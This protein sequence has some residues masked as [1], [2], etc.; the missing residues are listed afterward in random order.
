MT[1]STATK[2][3]DA[4]VAAIADMS[5]PQKN[6]NNPAFDSSYANLEAVFGAV[7]P[8]LTEHGIA[9]VQM[10]VSDD[11]GLGVHTIIAGH[12]ETMDLGEF[13][14]PLAKST[15]QAGG[16]ALTYA[17]RYSLASI[18]GLAQ[19]DDDG[20]AASAPVPDTVS[21]TTLAKL[22][23][24]VHEHGVSDDDY[25]KAL[26]ARGVTLDSDLTE[27]QARDMVARLAKK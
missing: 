3:L 9:V 26:E 4:L 12:G 16:S 25:A 22:R 6:A 10:P 13:T 23:K 19:V 5:N 2:L 15:A 7:K 27:A 11:R 17:R 14:L 21:D 20:A 8:H 1:A 18:F 24:A